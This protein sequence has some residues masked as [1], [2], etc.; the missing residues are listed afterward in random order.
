MQSKPHAWRKASSLLANLEKATRSSDS[1]RSDNINLRLPIPILDFPHLCISSTLPV[2]TIGSLRHRTPL[3]RRCS[4]SPHNTT[5]AP[6]PRLHIGFEIASL[7]VQPFVIDRST[8]HGSNSFRT[9][10]RKGKRQTCLQ[11]S[12]P[13]HSR[14]VI[15]SSPHINPTIVS[16]PTSAQLLRDPNMAFSRNQTRARM[17]VLPTVCRV[18]KD[19]ESAWRMHTLVSW[20]FNPSRA[21]KN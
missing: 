8:S 11:I 14:H 13:C 1:H 20:T 3:Y 2:Q 16:P 12:M 5:K 10:G 15:P 17:I 21:T 4:T 6:K 7:P 9:R 19:G 18:C